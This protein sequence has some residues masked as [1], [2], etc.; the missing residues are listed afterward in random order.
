MGLS[1]DASSFNPGVVLF[2][3]RG[4]PWDKWMMATTDHLSGLLWLGFIASQ[5]YWI[6]KHLTHATGGSC[7]EGTLFFGGFQG[8][9]ILLLME[10]LRW[11]GR[12]RSIQWSNSV[13]Y[14]TSRLAQWILWS[15]NQSC[16]AK[17]TRMHV[18]RS[19]IT[20]TLKRDPKN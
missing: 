2:G 4:G 5:K 6:Q 17:V 12:A 8:K 9:A 3:S 14:Q 19:Q 20:V 15:L 13:W 11:P 18:I 1:H 7:F 10:R 16:K